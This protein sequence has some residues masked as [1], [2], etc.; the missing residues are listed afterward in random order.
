[1]A[2]K[3]ADVLL[4]ERGLVE[5]RA[6]AQALIMAGLV[7][8]KDRRIAKAG[9]MLAEDTVLDLKGQD[10]PWVSR[11]GLKL[12]HA[13]SHF[14]LDPTGAIAVDVGASTGGFTDVLLTK[15]ATKVYAVDV[16]HG[17]IAWKLRSD[18]RVVV[19]EKT[20]A[21][22]LDET[23]IPDPIS[24]VVCDASFIGLRIVL[25]PAL[26]LCQPG[27]WAV[28]LIKPQFEAGRS[29]I[30]A[31]GVVRDAAVHERVCAEIRAW[32]EELEGWEVLGI[33]PSPIT[34][35]EGNREFLIAARRV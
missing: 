13:L 17:Q 4:V 21:R 8:T 26:A 32:W 10:H 9:D 11:G 14:G 7:F 35:P 29:E 23:I 22:T 27:G 16:G 33:E 19:M 18:P 30:G 12:D 1:M 28:A 2:K 34:G 24:I 3:R 6:R 5:S 15:G 31:K 20:N 25:P